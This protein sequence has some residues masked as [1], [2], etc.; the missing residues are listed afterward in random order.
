[1]VLKAES[2]FVSIKP[3]LKQAGAWYEIE[4]D[5]NPRKFQSSNWS[6]LM[7]EESFRNAVLRLMDEE[8]IV[9]FDTRQGDAKNYY[10][11]EDEEEV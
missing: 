9:K 10:N 7:K 1:M 11:L 4:I 8:V 3:F 6:D 2:I 5:G